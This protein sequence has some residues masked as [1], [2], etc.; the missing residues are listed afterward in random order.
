MNAGL[1]INY[2]CVSSISSSSKIEK[3]PDRKELI[4]IISTRYLLISLITR[5][6]LVD[7]ILINLSGRVVIYQ[8]NFPATPFDDMRNFA[9]RKWLTSLVVNNV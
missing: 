6:Y 2:A 9:I 8:S 4:K 3:V 7:M 5:K 1:A